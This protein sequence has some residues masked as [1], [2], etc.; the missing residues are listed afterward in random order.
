MGTIVTETASI[1]A[2]SILAVTIVE[3]IKDSSY[4]LA[5]ESYRATDYSSLDE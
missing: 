5:I 2:I 1:L 3:T 4:L